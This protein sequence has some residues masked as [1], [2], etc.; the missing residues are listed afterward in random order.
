MRNLL[1]NNVDKSAK[2]RVNRI[3]LVNDGA[4]K[5]I[6]LDKGCVKFL[7]TI[8]ELWNF[9][10][11]SCIGFNIDRDLWKS[12]NEY[13][14]KNVSELLHYINF[15]IDRGLRESADDKILWNKVIFNVET[16]NFDRFSLSC[17]IL[18]RSPIYFETYRANGSYSNKIF[19][20]QRRRNEE[21][22]LLK[23]FMSFHSPTPPPLK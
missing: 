8:E 19:E 15:N 23:C 14:F 3:L 16:N 22:K 1:F 7:I 13:P 4:S 2:N 20:Q 10:A 11:V 12:D 17:L 5:T 9:T 6:R 21:K 18:S